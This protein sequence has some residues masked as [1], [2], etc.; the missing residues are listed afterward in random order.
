MQNKVCLE[1]E[2]FAASHHTKEHNLYQIPS[3]GLLPFYEKPLQLD[4]AKS[5]LSLIFRQ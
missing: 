4:Q 5:D 2:E 3:H 1:L